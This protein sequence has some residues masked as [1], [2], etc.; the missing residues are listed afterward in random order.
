MASFAEWWATQDDQQD[1]RAAAE[2]AW[3]ARGNAD[4]QL[5]AE[6][7]RA[8]P[9]QLLLMAGEMTS[10]ELRT[11]R[12]ILEGFARQVELAPSIRD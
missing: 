1:P 7:L 12:A 10:D 5:V 6:L 11:V 2:A 8:T 4:R 3:E 9:Q